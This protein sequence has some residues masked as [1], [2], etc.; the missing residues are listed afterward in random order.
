MSTR[1]LVTL[2]NDADAD[3]VVRALYEAG[4]ESVTPPQ[5]ELPD[6][7][8]ATFDVDDLEPRIASI[9]TIAGVSEAEAD[10][11]A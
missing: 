4:A 7:A 5:P 2:E 1:I 9:R 8:I 3:E 11:L 6:V 10:V